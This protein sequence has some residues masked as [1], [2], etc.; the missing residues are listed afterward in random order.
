MRQ[1]AQF[2]ERANL[3]RKIERSRHVKLLHRRPVVQQHQQLDL[4]RSQIHHGGLDIRLVLHALQFQPLEIHLR[5]VAGLQ[6]VVAHLQQVVVIRQI[7]PRQ[8]QN[9]FLLQRLHE[10]RPQIEQQVSLLIGILRD[11]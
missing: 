7:L 10:R 11:A 5:D 3:I 6:P 9:R 8:I 4:R 1:A 2:F